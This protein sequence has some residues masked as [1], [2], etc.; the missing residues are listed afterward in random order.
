M[1]GETLYS[2]TR[3]EYVFNPVILTSYRLPS[4]LDTSVGGA[5]SLLAPRACIEKLSSRYLR[6]ASDLQM[7]PARVDAD[8]SVQ[9]LTHI[10]RDADEKRVDG[11]RLRE[12]QD[13]ESPASLFAGDVLPDHVDIGRS[14]AETPVPHAPPWG[15][16]QDDQV[17]LEFVPGVVEVRMSGHFLV[18]DD[19]L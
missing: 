15:S 14:G 19:L 11:L 3:L 8:Q 6:R 9:P 17:L 13:R 18:V 5:G 16:I 4:M 10:V 7:V 12:V 1:R 2:I